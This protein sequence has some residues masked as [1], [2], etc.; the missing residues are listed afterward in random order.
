MMLLFL[1]CFGVQ[2]SDKKIIDPK[3]EQHLT[4]PRVKQEDEVIRYLGAAIDDYIN[5][6]DWY[7]WDQKEDRLTPM[8]KIL[9]KGGYTPQEYKIKIWSLE[10]KN[11]V[12]HGYIIEMHV[13]FK[14]NPDLV[15]MDVWVID[16]R[17]ELESKGKKYKVQRL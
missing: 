4:D 3:I 13:F 9:Q 16:V 11:G 5:S 14:S 2:G 10:K 12:V 7:S 17:E 15:K 6:V 8:E 1:M